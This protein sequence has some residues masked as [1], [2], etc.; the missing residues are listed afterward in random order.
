[1]PF[2]MNLED[3]VVD[4]ERLDR[5]D[6]LT[7]D[8]DRDVADRDAEEQVAAEPADRQ[9]AVQILLRLADD[10]AAQPVAEPGRLR[11]D[12]R[13]GDD[14]DQQRADQGDDLQQQPLS[15]LRD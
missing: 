11:H 9:L 5:D 2:E 1:M 14:A 8:V 10:V 6:A 15:Q 12:E 13:E 3:A 7:R 4:L